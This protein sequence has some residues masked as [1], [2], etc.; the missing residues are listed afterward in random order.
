MALQRQVFEWRPEDSTSPLLVAIAQGEFDNVTY[1]MKHTQ[2]LADP[3]NDQALCVAAVF[4]RRDIVRFLIRRGIRA[5]PENGCNGSRP[6]DLADERGF[7][8]LAEELR[9]YRLQAQYMAL[10]KTCCHPSQ[11]RRFQ[12]LGQPSIRA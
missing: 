5:V 1:M 7:E 11:D 2:H 4:G 6:E 10:S 9:Q 3:P 12:P 8:A